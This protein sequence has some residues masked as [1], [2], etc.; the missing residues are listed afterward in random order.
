[1]SS[2]LGQTTVG[3][4][5]ANRIGQIGR[6]LSLLASPERHAMSSARQRSAPSRTNPQI[7]KAPRDGRR[8]EA[9]PGG[10]LP[11]GQSLGDVQLSELAFRKGGP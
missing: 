11:E 10:D 8:S 3:R 1:M 7:S 6:P 4:D 2:I 9:E 5:Q